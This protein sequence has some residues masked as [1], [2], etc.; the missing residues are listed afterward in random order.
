[1]VIKI[2]AKKALCIVYLTL[3]FT[4]TL[5]R[6][7]YYYPGLQIRKQELREVRS[8]GQGHVSVSSTLEIQTLPVHLKLVLW[9]ATLCFPLQK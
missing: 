1:M 8:L 3:T 2:T 5:G 6:K 9:N 4:P 7:Y